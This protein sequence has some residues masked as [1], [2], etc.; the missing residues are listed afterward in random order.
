MKKNIIITILLSLYGLCISFAQNNTNYYLESK[1]FTREDYTYQCDVPPYKLIKLYNK[2]N[3]LV[4]QDMTYKDSGNIFDG[5]AIEGPSD[6][7]RKMESIINGAFTEEEAA[8]FN[9]NLGIT[10]YLNPQTGDVMEVCFDFLNQ[11][12]YS[13]IPVERYR[14]LEL[15]LKSELKF[16]P[17]EIGR[18]LNFIRYYWM[19]IPTGVSNYIDRD[20]DNPTYTGE[21]IEP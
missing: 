11:S 10:L 6:M 13:N 3:Q 12:P 8:T 17:S 9:V 19:Q 16:T 18:Q 21:P 5:L 14:N 15:Q 20:L 7:Y 4:Y 2:G 1:T